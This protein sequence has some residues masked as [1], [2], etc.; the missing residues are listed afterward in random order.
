MVPNECLFFFHFEALNTGWKYPRQ[1]VQANS[2]L[3]VR[4]DRIADMRS[5]LDG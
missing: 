3:D 4:D 1:V 2:S 5:V